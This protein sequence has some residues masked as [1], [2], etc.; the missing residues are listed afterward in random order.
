MIA[1]VKLYIG[2]GCLILISLL[3]FFIQYLRYDND[4]LKQDISK[5][6]V[7]LL[8][9]QQKDLLQKK[10]IAAIESSMTVY[11]ATTAILQGKHIEDQK[12]IL[13]D[14]T[15]LDNTNRINGMFLRYVQS[16]S[17]VPQIPSAASKNDAESSDAKYYAAHRVAAGINEGLYQCQG[18]IIQLNT[19]IDLLN[20]LYAQQDEYYH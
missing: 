6:D 3:V 17:S 15:K 4:K 18:Y 12:R 19:L 9:W 1:Q 2:I 13:A 20:K 5:K 7:L 16:T 10:Q 11:I 14:K 8:Q